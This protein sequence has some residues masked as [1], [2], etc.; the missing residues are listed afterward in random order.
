MTWVAAIIVGWAIGAR[1]VC[2]GLVLM[3]LADTWNRRQK[4]HERI[5]EINIEVEAELPQ[6][7]RAFGQALNGEKDIVRILQKYRQISGPAL[8]YELDILITDLL[9]GDAEEAF[10]RFDER[11]NL[12]IITTFVSGVVGTTRGVD[13]QTFFYILEHDIKLLAHENLQRALAKRP[14]TI[15]RGS[16]LIFGSFMIMMVYPVIMLIV[17]NLKIFK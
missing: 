12:P 17:D 1:V 10:L 6:F 14:A 9:T 8:S 16:L 2:I 4:L 3:G 11:I 13:N 7:I 5:E 15:A